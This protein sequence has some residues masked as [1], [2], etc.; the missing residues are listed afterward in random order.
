MKNEHIKMVDRTPLGEVMTKL[1]WYIPS[2]DDRS[3]ETLV[4]KEWKDVP[5]HSVMDIV[6]KR[7]NTKP[8][9]FTTLDASDTIS[10][11]LGL[12][13]HL[14]VEQVKFLRAHDHLPRATDSSGLWMCGQELLKY[15]QSHNEQLE[16][17]KMEHFIMA[18]GLIQATGIEP[19]QTKKSR[20]K[21][22]PFYLIM[23]LIVLV[24]I[25][26]LFSI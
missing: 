25:I 14:N 17:R 18:R 23:S 6:T 24:L 26:I 4:G 20:E 11:A 1:F 22:N 7:F 10:S 13:D 8:H 5:L 12:V 21:I 15:E 16:S 9:D 19:K 3:L 2:R